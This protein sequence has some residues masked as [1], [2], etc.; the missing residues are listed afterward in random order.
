MHQ[1]R[2]AGFEAAA[3]EDIGPDG[4]I[5]LWNGRRLDRRETGRD[6]QR[7]AFVDDAIVGVAAAG[8]QRAP[9]A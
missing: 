8:D 3:V 1:Q 2:L 6:R 5:G 4:E 7:V 9:N